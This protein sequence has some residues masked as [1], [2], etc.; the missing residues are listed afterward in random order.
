MTVQGKAETDPV[1]VNDAD[2]WVYNGV[3]DDIY[4]KGIHAGAAPADLIE[5][6]A[7]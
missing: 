4:R 7:T 5:S 3:C 6:G 2:T 1:E